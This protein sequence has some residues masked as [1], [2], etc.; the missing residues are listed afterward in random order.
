MA[1]EVKNYVV[2][3]GNDMSELMTNVRVARERGWI[4]TGPIAHPA[5]DA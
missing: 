1:Q 3:T 5:V 2:A 4:T